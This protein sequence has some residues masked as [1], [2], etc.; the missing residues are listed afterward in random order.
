MDDKYIET[1][2]FVVSFLHSEGFHSAHHALLAE[3]AGRVKQGNTDGDLLPSESGQSP[4][5][6][7]RQSS[8]VSPAQSTGRSGHEEH[9]DEQTSAPADKSSP[10]P[11]PEAW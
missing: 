1:L 5:Q 10:A 7:T 9:E 11:E 2:N 6:V 8:G 3:F 4:S